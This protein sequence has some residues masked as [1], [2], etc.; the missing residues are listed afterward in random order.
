MIR[1]VL[2]VAMLT[3]AFNIPPGYAENDGNNSAHQHG[4][5]TSETSITPHSDFFD[6][7]SEV[8][9]GVWVGQYTNGTFENPTDWMPVRVEYR[10]ISRGSALVEDYFF[11]DETE[12]GM[13]TVYHIDNLELRLTHYCG[14]R[15]H[16]RMLATKIDHESR[17]AN[18]DF[19]DITNLATPHSYHSR[20]LDLKILS[21][22]HIQIQYHGLQEGEVASQAYDL[23]RQ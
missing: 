23:R 21:E 9:K 1:T 5:V 12:A 3:I 15:N 8:M 13:T 14:A 17:T 10:T 7:M 4:S 6:S 19:T 2:N 18:F 20:D 16:P 11:G 22:D